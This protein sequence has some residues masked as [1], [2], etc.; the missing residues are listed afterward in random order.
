MVRLS[1]V[2]T[3]DIIQASTQNTV[4][5]YI[6]DGVEFLNTGL[7]KVTGTEV[8][9]SD[10]DHF[11]S[12]TRMLGSAVIIGSVLTA[13]GSFTKIFTD[14]SGSLQTG[15]GSISGNIVVAGAASVTG[16]VTGSSVNAILDA[17][18]L[19][20]GTVLNAR[21][22]TDIS[23]TNVTA[24][25]SVVGTG[26]VYSTGK[27]GAGTSTLGSPLSVS[28]N[29]YVTAGSL[30]VGT[31]T[32]S[33]GSVLHVSGN[34][35]AT[36]SYSGYGGLLTGI[37]GGG[38]SESAMATATWVTSFTTTETTYQDVT[39]ATVTVSGL[40]AAKTY[41]LFCALSSN[42]RNDTNGN[43]A[44]VKLI[45]DTTGVVGSA[46]TGQV[47]VNGNEENLDIS[48]SKASATGS[49]SYIAKLQLKNGAAGTA[50]VNTFSLP[51][52]ITL[53]ALQV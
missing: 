34:V 39:N 14:V 8:I 21:L 16:L 30:M 5:D 28:G 53:I 1:D 24:S 33:S 22:P 10:Y 11:G 18:S 20:K 23:V 36:G 48:S 3:G 6:N 42:W 45:V 35:T 2:S 13:Y 4:N 37:G 47:F 31:S 52:R 51:S 40:S 12:N 41:N 7:V 27:I 17:G 26:S 49:T 50:G 19:T 46:E 15:Y 9:G 43:A 38:G 25:G 44:Y 32:N 29:A